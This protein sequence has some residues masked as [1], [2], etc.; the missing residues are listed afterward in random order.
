MS[1]C[2]LAILDFNNQALGAIF[3]L[4]I[5]LISQC[6]VEETSFSRVWSNI[7]EIFYPRCCQ[8]IFL[9]LYSFVSAL[10]GFQFL[11]KAVPFEG[12]QLILVKIWYEDAGMHSC[13]LSRTQIFE[14]L[15]IEPL[16]GKWWEQLRSTKAL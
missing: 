10:N 2:E 11:F 13:E 16:V 7:L 14:T 8:Y 1:I 3:S 15:N 6:H 12:E 4:K 9:C 5:L